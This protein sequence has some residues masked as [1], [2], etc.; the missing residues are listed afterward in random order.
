MFF[1]WSHGLGEYSVPDWLQGVHSFLIIHSH[2]MKLFIVWNVLAGDISS[3]AINSKKMNLN[4]TSLSFLKLL[5]PQKASSPMQPAQ[6]VFIKQ[7]LLLIRCSSQPDN[8]QLL[9]TSWSAERQLFRSWFN[10]SFVTAGF[11]WIVPHFWFSFVCT[12]LQI[13][14]VDIR[15]GSASSPSPRISASAARGNHAAHLADFHCPSLRSCRFTYTEDPNYGPY[16]ESVNGLPGNDKEHTYWELLV[17]PHNGKIERPDVGK[18][19]VTMPVI[20]LISCS[21]FTNCN[22]LYRSCS[23]VSDVTFQTRMIKSF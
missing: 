22:T 13:A 8:H 16:L 12:N 4:I 6:T 21:G 5:H 11:T 19:T 18:S 17:K 3:S 14:R 10:I 20:C 7:G 15:N 23:Q 2:K 1:L 9:E